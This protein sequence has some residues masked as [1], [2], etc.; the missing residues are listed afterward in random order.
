[1]RTFAALAAAALVAAER[2]LS[3][4]LNKI[5]QST[6]PKAKCIDGTAPAYY[7]RDGVGNGSQ[8]AILF[9]E[10]GGWCYPSDVEQMNGAN[11]AIRAKSGLGSSS[12]YAPTIAS[13]GYE[14]GAGYTSG[15][16]SKTA[17]ANWAA[18][19]VKYCD[20]G[21]MTGTREDPTPQRNGSAGQL[22]YRGKYNLDAQ[23]D[24][25]V[26]KHSLKS[27]KEIILSGCSAGGMACYLHCDYVAAY[28]KPIPVKC[29]CDAGIFLDVETGEHLPVPVHALLV[30]DQPH[31]QRGGHKASSLRQARRLGQQS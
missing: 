27:Y 25:M 20:G 23:L 29:I 26:A 6:S 10:G 1:M 3:L 13:M 4:S 19:Y 5:D 8:S 14:G 2:D 21:S 22:W 30:P 31:A 16:P 24:H 11:C 12:S 28:F 17:W 9:L 7:W 15:D 18:A